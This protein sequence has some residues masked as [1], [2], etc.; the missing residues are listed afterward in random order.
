MD[1]QPGRSHIATGANQAG[2]RLIDLP[3]LPVCQR[4]LVSWILRQ[5]TV[6][7]SDL[8]SHFAETEATISTWLEELIRQGY[9]QQT[10]EDGEYY[11]VRLATKRGYKFSPQILKALHLDQ[12]QS[13]TLESENLSNSSPPPE[14]T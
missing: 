3:K 5:N 10:G 14:A 11:Q 12:P 13:P 1:T 2:L 4:Q 9:V 6:T 8:V 7:F